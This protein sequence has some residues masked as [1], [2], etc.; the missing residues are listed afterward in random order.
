MILN[1]VCSRCGKSVEIPADAELMKL[2]IEEEQRVSE[3]IETIT[4]FVST[5]S[6]PLPEIITLVREQ[7]DAGNY[8]LRVD[9]LA[10][11]CGPDESKARNKG[12]CLNRVH[13]LVDEIH[14]NRKK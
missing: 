7:D 2:K 9:A 4:E 14:R 12:G 5:L 8:H 3:V 13:T 10:K 11:L 1:E 6:D